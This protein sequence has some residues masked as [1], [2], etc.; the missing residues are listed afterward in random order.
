ML[1]NQTRMRSMLNLIEAVDQGKKINL[2]EDIGGALTGGAIGSMVGGLPGAAIGGWLG[3]KVTGDDKEVS[4]DSGSSSDIETLANDALDAAAL[5]IQDALGVEHGD[6][7]GM[8]FTGEAGE[9][10]LEI[11]RDY[12]REEMKNKSEN[13]NSQTL[14]E[15]AMKRYLEDQA[16]SMEKE[17][18]VANADEYGMSSEEAV[19]W[20]NNCNGVDDELNEAASRKDFRQVAELIKEIPDESKRK[21]LA[22]HHCEIFKKQNPRFSREKFMKYIGIDESLNEDSGGDIEVNFINSGTGQKLGMKT[23]QAGSITLDNYGRPVMKVSS[24]FASG[25]TLMANF[26]S[27]T[28]G[29]VVDL[30]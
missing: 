16:M 27:K 2:N 1:D 29:W 3:D 28:G 7:A 30:D 12:A 8:F 18:F 24:P 14:D 15:G 26:D 13:D 19:E 10:I 23:V 22:N 4:E 25:N 17:D 11:L 21:E 5:S 20:W 6:F 9:T